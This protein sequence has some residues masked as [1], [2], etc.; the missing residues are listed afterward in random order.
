MRLT[1]RVLPC[2]FTVLAAIAMW[3][4]LTDRPAVAKDKKKAPAPARTPDA[5]A[6]LSGQCASID[7]ALHRDYPAM[8]L[9]PAG[10]PWIA[11]IEHDGKADTLKLA[12]RTDAGLT[13]IATVSTPGVI[14]Q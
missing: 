9:D 11:F 7:P 13:T 8:C 6:V 12:R 3:Q 5:M 14:H 4:G 10:T 2:V 1:R